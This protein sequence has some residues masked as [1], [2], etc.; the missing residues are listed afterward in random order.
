M[1]ANQQ[2]RVWN[3]VLESKFVDGSQIKPAFEKKD[4]DIRMP[5]NLS[6]KLEIER[7]RGREIERKKERETVQAQE[8]R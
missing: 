6:R 7:T 3:Y 1:H 2:I 8:L 4:W 5:Q